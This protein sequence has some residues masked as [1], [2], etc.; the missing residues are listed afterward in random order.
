MILFLG[1]S[2][3]NF[4]LNNQSLSSEEFPKVFIKNEKFQTVF[5]ESFVTPIWTQAS[6]GETAN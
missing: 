5:G 3:H 6:R 2:S 4:H 1:G